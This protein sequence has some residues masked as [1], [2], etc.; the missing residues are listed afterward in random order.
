[1][2]TFE[3]VLNTLVTLAAVA[4]GFGAALAIATLWLRS[5]M[6]AITRTSYNVSSVPDISAAVMGSRLGSD[7]R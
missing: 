2:N 3:T 5:I 6:S 1:M 7:V 4:L